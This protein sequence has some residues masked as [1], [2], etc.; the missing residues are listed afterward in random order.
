MTAILALCDRAILL[1][2]GRVRLDASSEVAILEYLGG[3][4]PDETTD[5][6]LTG[7]KYRQ[8]AFPEIIRKATLRRKNLCKALCFSSEEVFVCDINLALPRKISF[9]RWRWPLKMSSA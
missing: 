3:A 1:G 4:S 8:P 7:Y 9:P 6:D 2:D 5:Y